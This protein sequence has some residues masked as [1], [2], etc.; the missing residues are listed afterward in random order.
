MPPRKSPRKKK[1][2]ARRRSPGRRSPRK[3]T[4]RSPSPRRRIKNSPCAVYSKARCGAVDPNC[5]W[6][7]GRG[8]GLRRNVH[9]GAVYEGPRMF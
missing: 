3:S 5:T 4:R 1:S 2:P 8:C 9:K 6:S 7:V